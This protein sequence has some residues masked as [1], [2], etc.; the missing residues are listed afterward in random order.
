MDR[1]SS[2]RT[3]RLWSVLVLAFVV[4]AL[5]GLV[6]NWR[7]LS[8]II[9]LLPEEQVRIPDVRRETTVEESARTAAA[10]IA[11]RTI[12]R[13]IA[14]SDDGT[15]GEEPSVGTGIVLSDDGLF[16]VLLQAGAPERIAVQ[17]EAGFVVPLARIGVDPW[18]GAILARGSVQSI[19]AG[20]LTAA[21][22]VDAVPQLGQHLLS[23]RADRSLLVDA[24]L[25]AMRPTGGMRDDAAADTLVF[26]PAPAAPTV[27][28]DLT[29]GVVAAALSDTSVLSAASIDGLFREFQ[30]S[31]AVARPRF[32]VTLRDLLPGEDPQNPV[33]GA[34]I[35]DI[36][37]GG[38]FAA[39]G[40]AVGD[41]ILSVNGRKITNEYRV[42]DALI[43]QLP[44]RTMDVELQRGDQYL[45]V[46]VVPERRA[47]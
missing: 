17:S 1:S 41:R 11:Q 43:R 6:A 40:A 27:Y 13:I 46:E 45:M 39:A 28:L 35:M 9:G 12:V 2:T 37:P 3:P 42:A 21:V 30:Q 22:I 15:Y 20:E 25:L 44:M 26:R 29:G 8:S 16:L 32:G 14:L 24:A 18:S 36:A 5:G 38:P 4:G 34:R 7:T 23:A 31:G 47:S 33:F 19:P 10:A